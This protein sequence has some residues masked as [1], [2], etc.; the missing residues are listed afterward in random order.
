MPPIMIGVLALQGA[1][2]KHV[3]MLNSLGVEAK[4]VRTLQDLEGCDGLI[5]PGGEST[6]MMRQIDFIKL[7]DDLK[8]FAQEK[9][10]FGTCAGLILMSHEV[11][12]SQMIPFGI[13]DVA[14]ERNAFGRQ[15]ESFIANIEIT[16]DQ[17]TDKN[18]P[19]V[20]IRAP[21][22]RSCGSPVQTLAKFQDEPVLVQQGMHMG[23]TFHPELT[24]N[25]F[26]HRYFLSLV[27][28]RKKAKSQNKL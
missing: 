25:A 13:L 10:L 3:E 19:A 2:A 24:H 15:A 12:T 18:F 22:I 4:E 16:L 20:F 5:I 9:P 6:T 7:A 26:I 1:F 27:K 11:L 8:E 28:E 21:R 14:V 17:H 23:A